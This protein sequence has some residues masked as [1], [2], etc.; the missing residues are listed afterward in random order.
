MFSNFDVRHSYSVLTLVPRSDSSYL[1][2][3]LLKWKIGFEYNQLS[4]V[5]VVHELFIRVCS[6]RRQY[7]NVGL[8]SYQNMINGLRT[9]CRDSFSFFFS[10][11]FF[12]QKDKM[13]DEYWSKAQTIA[14]TVQMCSNIVVYR[15]A[16]LLMRHRRKDT[17]THTDS[18]TKRNSMN[19]SLPW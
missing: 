1:F 16:H 7:A 8:S 4:Q 11:L 5:C 15:C 3:T 14:G 18:C 2:D 12:N 19:L 9:L 13:Y 17:D 10:L 6:V